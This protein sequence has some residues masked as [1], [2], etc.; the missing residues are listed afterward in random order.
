M[1]FCRTDTAWYVKQFF[2]NV[3]MAN[4]TAGTRLGPRT[5]R[6]KR[7]APISAIDDT[8][9]HAAARLSTASL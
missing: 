1:A 5:L 2:S 8:H 6:A 9:A 4:L 3:A 7:D